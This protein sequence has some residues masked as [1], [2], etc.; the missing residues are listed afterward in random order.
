MTNKTVK[1]WF[2]AAVPAPTDKRLN[3]Q[4]GCHLEE[5]C[6]MLEAITTVPGFEHLEQVI[7]VAWGNLSTLADFLKSGEMEVEPESKINLLD[8]ICD[9]QVTG[10]GVAHMLGMDIDGA[11]A[12]VNQSNWSKFVDGKPVFNEQGK[13]AKGADY[14]AP[15]LERFV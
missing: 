12:E 3:I 7:D 6:E 15:E 8:S 11:M 13:I 10:I 4:I 9:Q 14:K 2:E 5:V 1:Q